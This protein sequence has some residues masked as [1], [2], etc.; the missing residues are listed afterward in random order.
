M[1]MTFRNVFPSSR[2]EPEVIA[3]FGQAKLVRTLEGIYE[4]R[5]G[6][7]DDRAEAKEWISIFMHEVAFKT[8]PAHRS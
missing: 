7:A 5:G 3:I 1:N 8:N 4:L 2:P 6:S